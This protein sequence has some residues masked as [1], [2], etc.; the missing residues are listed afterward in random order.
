MSR[1]LLRCVLRWAYHLLY[2]QFAWTYDSVAWMVS[3]GQWRE[4]GRTV[5][6]YLRGP[7]I[8]DLAHGPG[9]LTAEMKVQGYQVVGYDLSPSMSRLAQRNAARKDVTVP[10]ARGLAQGLP[11]PAGAFTSVVATFPAGFIL[12][13]VT[14]REVRRVLAADGIFLMVPAALHSGGGFLA[15]LQVLLSAPVGESPSA[16]SDLFDQL[17]A[18]DFDSQLEWVSLPCSRVLLIRNYPLTTRPSGRAI[19]GD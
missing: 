19:A 13:P 5:L 7:R 11:F 4:W 16:G 15:R 8:L 6:P 17:A 1:S 18:H 12:H 2:N 14:W 3:L 9:H 10:L